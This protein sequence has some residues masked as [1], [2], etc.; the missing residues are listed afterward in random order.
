VRRETGK[1]YEVKVL[2]DEDVANHIGPKLCVLFREDQGE[3]SA[4]DVGLSA[5]APSPPMANLDPGSL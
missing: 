3:A 4:E 1:E 2:Y 5:I